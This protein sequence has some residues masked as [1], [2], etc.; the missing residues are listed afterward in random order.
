MKPPPRLHVFNCLVKKV[1][2]NLFAVSRRGIFRPST[3]LPPNRLAYNVSYCPRFELRA[4]GL[5]KV[6][7]WPVFLAIFRFLGIGL[8]FSL[9]TFALVVLVPLPFRVPCQ[10]L[11]N[12]PKKSARKS[13]KK[14]STSSPAKTKANKALLRL[15]PPNHGLI[16]K[17]NTSHS[18]AILQAINVLPNFWQRLTAESADPPP[19]I[20]AFLLTPLSTSAHQMQLLILCSSGT[21]SKLL[22]V[23]RAFPILYSMLSTMLLT[24]CGIS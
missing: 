7:S 13:T 11:P 15:V 5:T 21:V 24:C 10:E 8:V 17:G 12:L 18:I 9:T 4:R 1:F 2:K 6:S 22:S 16:N 19:L 20:A 3:L 23:V 14:A